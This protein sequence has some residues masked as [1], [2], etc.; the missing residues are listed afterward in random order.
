MLIPLSKQA[1]LSKPLSKQAQLRKPL[2]LYNSGNTTE[3]PR[4]RKPQS[5]QAQLWKPLSN[6]DLTETISLTSTLPRGQITIVPNITQ[7]SHP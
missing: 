6:G 1:Q 3:H 2:S 5:K 7:R 4:L